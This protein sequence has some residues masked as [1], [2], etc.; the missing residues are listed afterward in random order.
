M[1]L[2]SLKEFQAD[3][4]GFL[5]DSVQRYGDLVRFR[6]GYITAY[7][8]NR[9]EYVE[10]ILV[11]GAKNYD[12]NTRSV[13]K[14]RATC[15]NSLLSS[16]GESWLKHRRLIQPVFQPRNVSEFAAA[17]D[18]ATS[19]MLGHWNQQVSRGNDID[20]VSEM[21]SLTMTIAAN[22]FF[23][24]DIREQTET[25]ERALEVVL[26]DTWRR[27]QAPIDLAMISK[28]FQRPTFRRALQTIDSIVYQIIQQRRQSRSTHDD[29]LSKL[30]SAHE[31]S[32]HDSDDQ[33]RLDDQELR[34]AVVT[35]LLA[36]HE[37]TANALA[38]AFYLI[39]QSESTEDRLVCESAEFDSGPGD[40]QPDVG[41]SSVARNAFFETI[42]LFP[43][44]WII[45]RR[46]KFD[47][48]IG[49]HFIPKGSTVLVSPYLLHRHAEFWDD[50]LLFV[51]DRFDA[52]R[53][54]DRPRSAYI[55][56]GMG[57]HRCIGEHMA[58][59]VATR[60]LN[61][62][63]QDYRLRLVPGQ[64]LARVPGITLRHGG[65]IWMTPHRNATCGIDSGGQSA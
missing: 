64:T 14:L 42:R 40:I 10:Q 46:A 31:L 53:S 55:P 3:S 22:V 21:M 44:I 60:I 19:E 2:G 58:V 51:P 45:E 9:P 20:L 28:T 33:N 6:F 57:P 1:L 34:D 62:V 35:L 61:R 52:G 13:S 26:A 56:F 5:G 43:S 17:I 12:K 4:I 30:L 48:R 24:T 16:D 18:A 29:I 39:S 37:T 27:L 50:P 54:S 7:L 65:P 32:A 63:Y 36:G 11:R 38:N 23:A 8:L 25:I 59:A 49:G 15:G 41:R 47:D